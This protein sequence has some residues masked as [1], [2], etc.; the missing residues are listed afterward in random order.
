MRIFGHKL[1]AL[2][3]R[4]IETTSF[5]QYRSEYDNWKGLAVLRHLKMLIR[6]IREAKSLSKSPRRRGRAMGDDLAKG[7]ETSIAEVPRPRLR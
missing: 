5:H 6:R 7:T 2:D 1:G 3:E 4:E